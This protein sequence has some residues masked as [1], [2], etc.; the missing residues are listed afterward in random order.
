MPSQHRLRLV[1]V[2]SIKNCGPSKPRSLTARWHSLTSRQLTLDFER[3]ERIRPGE[4]ARVA[5]IVRGL[6]AEVVPPD[7]R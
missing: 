5:R 6:L 2:N 3:L 7:E 1:Y 4:A